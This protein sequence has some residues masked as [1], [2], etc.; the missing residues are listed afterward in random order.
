VDFE[1]VIKLIVA[2]AAGVAIPVAAYAAIVATRAIR[3]KP[4]RR[5]PEPESEELE[6][7]RTRVAEL[8]SLRGRML[9]L[10]ERL[11]FAERVLVQQRDTARLPGGTEDR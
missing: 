5:E 3:V 2:I 10:E 6:D 7:L 9:E 8:E 4:V 11:D 1:P